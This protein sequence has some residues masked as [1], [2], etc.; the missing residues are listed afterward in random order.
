[1]GD[2]FNDSFDLSI[3][4]RYGDLDIRGVAAKNRLLPLRDYFD[5]LK[6]FQV[7]V[8]EI[9]NALNRITNQNSN[10]KDLQ[11]LADCRNTLESI[12]AGKLIQDINNVID[13][14]KK[15]D[16]KFASSSAYKILEFLTLLD[17]HL[18]KAMKKTDISDEL[19]EKVKSPHDVYSQPQGT[20]SLKKA[21][22][23]LDFAEASRKMRILAVDDA[24]VMLKIVSGVLSNDYDVYGIAN[25]KM[26]ENFLQQITPELFILDY[27][28]PGR[29][30]FELVPIIRS[31]KEHKNTPII[32]LTSQG[33]IDNISAAVTLGASDFIVKPF[34]AEILREKIAK[35]IVRKKLF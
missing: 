5:F 28:M 6:K 29:S 27:M 21:L 2:A 17:E 30:G 22:Q 23:L 35:H 9:E 7:D 3:L 25:P 11:N 24:P 19:Q 1:M 26:V 10:N 33:T 20:Y 14:V 34:H 32:F 31:F 16:K 12:G 18:L 8:Y 13:A 15:N 4:L